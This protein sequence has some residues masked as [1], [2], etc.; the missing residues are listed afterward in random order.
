MK[1]IIIFLLIYIVLLP[2][3]IFAN[4]QQLEE[5]VGTAI[6]LMER[7]TGRVLFER[8]A[9]MLI[10]PASM[11][12][13]LTAIVMLDYIQ[14]DD[15]IRVSNEIYH[16]PFG[17]S[18]AGHFY[19]EHISGLN[20][21]RALL[22]PS[23]NDSANVVVA[24]VVRLHT[25]ENMPFPQ[26]EQVFANLMNEKARQIGAIHSNFTNAHG[27]HDPQM[28]STARDLAIISDYAMNIPIIRQVAAEL[29][30]SGPS[31]ENPAPNQPTQQLSWSN[32]NRL[33]VGQYHNPYA[34]GL[35]TGFHTPA[36]W[37]FIGTAYKDG[38]DIITVI[39]GSYASQRWFDTTTL[40]NYA[41]DN[42]EM[43]NVHYGSDVIYEIDIHNPRWGDEATAT[44]TGTTD[45]SYLLSE[46]ELDSIQR[47]VV[48]LSDIAYES[49]GNLA[50]IAPLH[51]GDIIGSV[52]YTLNG[53]ELFR[54]DIIIVQDIYPW[55]Y[56]A[57]F[58][59]VIGY[60]TENPF[61]IFGLSLM[62]ALI[63]LSIVLYKLIVIAKR[64]RA[65]R[66]RNYGFRSSKF[67]Y[68]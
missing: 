30:F 16:V 18:L 47:D 55:S 32:T 28:Q 23:G 19:A 21:L 61:S 14:P 57:S 38:L 43:R 9:D 66:S 35:K 17:S 24:N 64:I 5:L 53:A 50:F 37:C 44:V 22:L 26:A 25:G 58:R 41:F 49:D 34:T 36:G 15:V 63:F 39:A 65:K 51:A 56:S 68:K 54:D 67:K 13:V 59:F 27:F 40:F 52:I 7:N 60:L 10:Y 11:I 42:Y 1:K 46:V 62:L 48:F 29:H 8:N 20:L 45:F 31:L 2:T 6:I 3:S 12:K 33:L 4:R